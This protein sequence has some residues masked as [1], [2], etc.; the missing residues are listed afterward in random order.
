[1]AYPPNIPRP[2][3]P[4]RKTEIK[5]EARIERRYKYLL[6]TAP[7][8]ILEIDNAGRIVLMNAATERMFGYTR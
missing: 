7:D 5:N 8:A 1:M 3:S 2:E 4:V 6:E